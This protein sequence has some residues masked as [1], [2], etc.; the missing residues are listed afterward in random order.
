MND[1]PDSSDTDIVIDMRDAAWRLSFPG[2]ADVVRTAARA[3]LAA[4]PEAARLPRP[5]ELSILLADDAFVRGLNRDH[6]GEDRPTNVLSFAAWDEAAPHSSPHGQTLLLG[7]IVLAR[8]TLLREALAAG[9]APAAHLSHLVVHGVL[10]LLGY[11]HQLDAAAARMEALE[12]RILA[13]LGYPDPYSDGGTG[14]AGR[15][16]RLAGTLQH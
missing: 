5:I 13:D 16:L 9:A 3:A 4:A 11:D 14:Q 2:V 1:D 7:D 6:R 15:G 10:H 8:E 12:T